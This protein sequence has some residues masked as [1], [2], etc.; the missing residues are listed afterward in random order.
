[1][2]ITFYAKG[3]TIIEAK[4][5][6]PGSTTDKLDITQSMEEELVDTDGDMIPN[7]AEILSGSD[8]VKKDECEKKVFYEDG[9]GDGYGEA[10]TLVACSKPKGY[11][12]KGGDCNEG[13]ASIYPGAPLNCNNSQD[14]DCDGQIDEVKTTFYRDADGD[15]YGS[16]S[17]TTQACSQPSGYVSNSGD[18][19]DSNRWINP[20]V[21]EICDDSIDN[22]CNSQT[23]EF[24]CI[25][26]Q[27]VSGG[28]W[29]TCAIKSDGSLWCWGWN[30]YGQLGLRDTIDRNYPVWVSDITDVVQ[31]IAGSE[32]T[33][34]VKSDKS[35]W[36]WGWNFYGQLGLRDTANRNYPV[37]VSDIT[38]VVQVVAG[39]EHTC[40]VKSDGSLW[41]WGKNANGQLG[42]GDTTNR[43]SPVQVSGIA[44]VVRV[45][46]GNYHTCAIKS[47]GSLWCWGWNNFGAL[48]LGDTTDR[49]YPAW[50]SGIT[51]VFRVG[52]GDSYTCAIK[53]DNSLWCWG[54]NFY[55]Q[56]GLGDTIDRYSPT[57]VSSSWGAPK[58]SVSVPDKFEKS[59]EFYGGENRWYGCNAVSV[60]SESAIFALP[61]IYYLLR[62]RIRRKNTRKPFALK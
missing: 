39:A 28:D 23:D 3:I 11:A 25:V 54:Y 53:S 47:D 9:D 20:G 45:G 56:L 7:L 31:V 44:N 6:F 55:G 38:D 51:N 58:I 36:C 4:G 2:E 57:Q 62:R 30:F 33:C 40:A 13:N 22:N 18:C 32:H 15:G 48:G 17:S 34:A 42:V 60:L 5:K 21:K 29:H 37:W 8:P 61:Y 26:Q 14:N 19:N 16:P 59:E 35:L 49:Y 1:M 50:V 10:I 12:D 27:K 43:T 41:C 24:P 46:A 52:G